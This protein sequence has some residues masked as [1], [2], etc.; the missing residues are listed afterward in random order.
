MDAEFEKKVAFEEVEIHSAELK[1]LIM[2][3]DVMWRDI[4][5]GQ[6][7][8]CSSPFYRF[9]WAWDRYT[10]AC[11]PKEDDTEAKKI[12][13]QDLKEILQ[14]VRASKGLESYFRFRDPYKMPRRSDMSI[15]G[16]FSRMAVRY[17][18]ARI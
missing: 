12:A 17:M 8:I 1:R 6:Q 2:E 15:Y 18:P 5:E 11:E 10:T 13:R 9:V 7:F 16:L 3:T 14:H 4:E